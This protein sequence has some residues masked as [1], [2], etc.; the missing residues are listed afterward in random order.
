MSRREHSYRILA[1]RRIKR[2]AILFIVLLLLILIS[3]LVVGFRAGSADDLF[4]LED[5]RRSR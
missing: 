5:V 3:A 1:P 4:F 2:D